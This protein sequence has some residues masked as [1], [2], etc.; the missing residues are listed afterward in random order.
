[1]SLVTDDRLRVA[2]DFDVRGAGYARSVWHRLYAEGLVTHSA[3]RSGDRV[4]DAGVGTGFAAIAAAKRAGPNGCVVGVDISPGMLQQ[5]RAAV[6]AEQLRSVELLQADACDLRDLPSHA[7]DAIICA[8]ALLY[9]PVQAAL[10]EWRRLLKPGGTI[11]FSTMRAGFPQAGR[12]FR[13]CAG[14]FGVRLADPSAPLGTE[15]AAE[16]ALRQAGFVDIRMIP[17]RVQFAEDDFCYAW[18]SN[19][20]SAAHQEV[21]NLAPASLEALR[22]RFEQVLEDSRRDDPSF[23]VAEV[24]YAYGTR[25]AERRLSPFAAVSSA[26]TS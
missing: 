12:L 17:D 13:D 24:L 14:G 20:R 5:A 21:R 2:A 25:P 16:G 8:A 26:L 7:F 4:L 11:G 6:E 19:L 22:A 1:M 3:I 18:E 23:A 15:A 10:A 9:M